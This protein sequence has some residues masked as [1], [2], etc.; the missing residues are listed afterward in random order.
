MIAPNLSIVTIRGRESK[1]E[2]PE[3]T[4]VELQGTLAQRDGASAVAGREIGDMEISEDR[5]TAILKI[6][7]HQLKG[8][9]V[10]LSKACVV[11]RKRTDEDG[12][13]LDDDGD[14]DLDGGNQSS[15]YKVVAVVRHKYIFKHRP[16]PID[17]LQHKKQR[18]GFVQKEKP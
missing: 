9:L 13:V 4:A 14:F 15:E 1:D 6:G 2:I 11:T 7:N 3:W 5:K 16:K 10:K 8:Q 18:L 17:G 12:P